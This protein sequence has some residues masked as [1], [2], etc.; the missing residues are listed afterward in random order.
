MVDV[1]IDDQEY[2]KY[3]NSGPYNSPSDLDDELGGE[4]PLWG[5]RKATTG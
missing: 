4:S 3:Y 2:W 1:I 5:L